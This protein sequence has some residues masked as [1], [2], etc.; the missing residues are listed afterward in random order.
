MLCV[1]DGALADAGDGAAPGPAAAR[2][3]NP[4]W[5][6]SADQRLGGGY[7]S[8]P[9]L[10]PAPELRRDQGGPVEGLLPVVTRLSTAAQQW[11]QRTGSWVGIR[12][13]SCSK[14]QVSRRQGPGA[15][16]ACC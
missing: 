13:A 1:C 8:N 14:R 15:S 12:Y 9:T 16:T 2:G 3:T 5:Q 7:D 11:G 6:L 10:S 4:R